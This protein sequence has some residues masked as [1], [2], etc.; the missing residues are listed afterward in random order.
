MDYI[1]FGTFSG[2]TGGKHC[3]KLYSDGRLTNVTRVMYSSGDS[4]HVI[5]VIDSLITNN[6]FQLF[7]ASILNM[8]FDNILANMSYI[9]IYRYNGIEKK[10]VFELGNVPPFLNKITNELNKLK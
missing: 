10:W 1:E 2:F 9:L 7:D 6:I 8:N 3:R 4:E 5:T